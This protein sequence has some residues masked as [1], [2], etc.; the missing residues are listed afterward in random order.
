MTVYNN[1]NSVKSRHANTAKVII[2][3]EVVA[4][5]MSISVQESGGTDQTYTVGE[6]KPQESI[7]NRYSASAQIQRVIFK[8][9]ALQKYTMGGSGL[10]DL[11]TFTIQ[12]I[13]EID[14]AVLFTLIG[15]TLASRSTNIQANQRIMSDV[16]VLALDCQDKDGQVSGGSTFGQ[17]GGAGAAT[18]NDTTPRGGSAGLGR[19]VP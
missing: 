14:G 15:C 16:Q 5:C 17:D 12:A 9:G 8:D 7:H 18:T 13:D 1:Y 2:D 10:L 6:A 19:P 11:P 3:G 4:E